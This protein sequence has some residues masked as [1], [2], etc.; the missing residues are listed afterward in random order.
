MDYFYIMVL[1]SEYLLLSFLNIISRDDVDEPKL[2]SPIPA[3]P[4]F[5]LLTASETFKSFVINSVA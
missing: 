2:T 5:D 3:P 1:S 4:L